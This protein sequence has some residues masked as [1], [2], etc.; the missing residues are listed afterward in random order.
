MNANER[1]MRPDTVRRR[2]EMRSAYRHLAHAYK[3]ASLAHLVVSRSHRDPEERAKHAQSAKLAW[4]LG[5]ELQ[6]EIVG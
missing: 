3:S 4:Q 2:R 1:D 5:Q 6:A